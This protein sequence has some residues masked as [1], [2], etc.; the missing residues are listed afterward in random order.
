[1]PLLL[2]SSSYYPLSSVNESKDGIS[3]S[4]RIKQLQAR[5]LKQI[6]SLQRSIHIHEQH[7]KNSMPGVQSL[8]EASQECPSLAACVLCDHS[9]TQS[10]LN[11]VKAHNTVRCAGGKDCSEKALPFTRF[12]LKRMY[13]KNVF[14]P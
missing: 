13:R 8:V 6:T 1:M 10:T 4:E 12:C 2:P 7:L 5:L 11:V 3:L 14:I 9:A